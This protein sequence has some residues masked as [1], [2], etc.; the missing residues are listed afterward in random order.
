ME[1][2]FSYANSYKAWNKVLYESQELNCLHLTS[3]LANSQ[4]ESSKFIRDKY[5]GNSIIFIHIYQVIERAIF[6]LY[7]WIIVYK[8][9]LISGRIQQCCILITK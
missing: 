2:E 5:K 3:K 1:M 6:I 4:D 8:F 9:I 7:E